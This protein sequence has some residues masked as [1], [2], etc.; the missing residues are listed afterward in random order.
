MLHCKA[1][2]AKKMK[3]KQS[4]Q[5]ILES[6]FLDVVTIINEIRTKPKV[7]R[8]FSAFGKYSSADHDTLILHTE[9]RF[10][11]REKV[12][13]RFICLKDTMNNFLV[14][15]KSSSAKLFN[16]LKWFVWSPL[17]VK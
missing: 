14:E 8:E 1:V 13:E 2:V 11:S 6:I 9:A 16:D 17:L 15:R 12:L 5:H 7:S 10:L 4:E 3:S